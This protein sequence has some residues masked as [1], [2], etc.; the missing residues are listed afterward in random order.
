MM[1][2]KWWKERVVYQIYPRSFYDSNGDGIG[3]IPGIIE[4]L[5]VLKDLGVGI[6]WLSPVYCS[7]NEDNGYDISD[8]R[9]INPEFGTMADME[10]LIAEANRRDIRIVMDLVVN[11]TSKEHEWFQKSRDKDSPYRDY[12]IWRPGKGEG[13][14]P[15]NW[16]SFFAEDCWEFDE[17]SN[18][19]Y[20]HLFARGMPDLNYH[21]PRVV[22]EVKDILRFWLDKGVSGFRCDVINVIYKTSLADG[23]KKFILT[24]SEHYISQPGCHKLLQEFRREVLDGYDCFTVGETV[25][26]TP[27]MGRDLCDPERKE[28]DMIFTFEHMETDQFLVKWFKTRFQPQKFANTIV[29]WQ[30]ALNWN[31]NYLENHDQPRSVSRFGDDQAHWKESAKLLLTLVLT[32]RG[33]PYLYQ[34]QEIG[35]TNFDF[36]SMDDIR[37]V[38]S[39]NVYRLATKIHLP[40]AYRWRMMQRTSRDNARTPVQWNDTR[41]AGFTVG[42]PWLKVNSNYPRINVEQQMADDTSI[43]SFCKQLIALRASDEALLY[44]EFSVLAI[45]KE[46]FVYRRTLNGRAYTVL[47]NFSKKTI[48]ADYRGRLVFSNYSGD[49]YS[50]SLKPYEAALLYNEVIL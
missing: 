43:R 48:P 3:D 27:Q 47:L 2:P 26:V 13:K 5:D 42:T 44:G 21:N 34:G 19:Y 7:P 4:K 36:S 30:K 14:P 37:D 25:F 40:R 50:G 28:L 46:L 49:A 29:T 1:Q 32:L 11:H 23:K 31:A 38:E 16:T 45:T 12:Y 22:E 6:L 9:N 15:N 39:L 35:M 24:G 41:N 20:L 33:T 17:Q 10:R 8:Y 18:E